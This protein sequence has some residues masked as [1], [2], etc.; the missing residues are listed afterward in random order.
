VSRDAGADPRQG[1]DEPLLPNAAI[2][3][4]REYAERVNS[5]LFH[6]S[7]LLLATLAVVVAFIPFLIRVADRSTTTTVVVAA[8]DVALAQRSVDV[9]SNVLNTGTPE[10]AELPFAVRSVASAADARGMVESGA[11]DGL[12]IVER[13]T[14][15][16]LGFEF[17][18]GDAVGEDRRQLVSIGAFAIAVL[19]YTATN[20]GSAEFRLPDVRQQ[21]VGGPGGGH[22]VSAA[23]YASRRV[24]GVV[25]VVLIFITLVI[26]GMWVAA[27]VVTEKTSRVMELMIS[28]ASPRQLVVGKVAGIGAA[29]L[30]QAVAILAPALLALAIEDPLATALLGPGPAVAPSLA[31]LS[32]GLVAAFLV[33]FTLGFVLYALIY[34]AAGSLVSRAEDLQ[35]LALP[36]SLVAI[37]GYVQAV[38]ALTGGLAG[39]LRLASYVPFW[40]PFVMLTR[41]TVGRVEPWELVLSLGLL[42]VTIGATYVVAVRIYAA[43][44]LLYG[45]R[46][47]LRAIVGAA[48]ARG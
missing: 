23:E 34:A 7:T 20:P 4:R 37:V 15:G 33:Y 45:Q 29:G 13:A 46:P 38:M 47:G 30:T 10:G 18:A 1:R 3:A 31:G 5:R 25:F 16:R 28:A 36:L 24:V 32:V 21:S 22:P 12:L 26:Y 39:F 27:G 6:L 19:D 41:L 35:M 42:V 8:S 48:L 14:S 43:G 2:V 44:V 17:Q 11:A 9:L 40:S